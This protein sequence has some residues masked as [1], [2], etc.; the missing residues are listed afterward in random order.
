L[1]AVDAPGARVL[2]AF[3]DAVV[4]G[5]AND[6]RARFL[7]AAGEYAARV[8]DAVSAGGLAGARTG[9]RRDATLRRGVVRD[10]IVVAAVCGAFVHYGL[11]VGFLRVVG[12]VVRAALGDVRAAAF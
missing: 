11:D 4:V 2:P 6:V 1:R 12:C 10:R 5:R 8:I 9:A 7:F 3:D